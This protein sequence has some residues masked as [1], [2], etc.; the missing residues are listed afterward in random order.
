VQRDLAVGGPITP[1][2]TNAPAAKFLINGGGVYTE[3][4][5]VWTH[6][7]IAC[8]KPDDCSGC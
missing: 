2:E 1:G 7:V 6:T 4:S 8:N 3:S 5:I